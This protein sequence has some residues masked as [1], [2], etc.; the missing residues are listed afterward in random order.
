[1]TQGLTYA[2]IA[3]R[4]N[5]SEAAI[6]SQLLVVYRRLGMARSSGKATRA[7][8]LYTCYFERMEHHDER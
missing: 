1:M 5:T 8:C 6:K 2:Q 7:V 3:S 4:R